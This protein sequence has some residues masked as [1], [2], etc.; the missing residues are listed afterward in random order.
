[1]NKFTLAIIGAIALIALSPNASAK[2][3]WK[4]KKPEH[5]EAKYIR[6]AETAITGINFHI[7]VRNGD[8]YI[9]AYFGSHFK[10][11]RMTVDSSTPL[12]LH[13]MD[14]DILLF[15]TTESESKKTVVLFFLNNKKTE[16][17][18]SIS[19]EVLNKLGQEELIGIQTSFKTDGEIKQQDYVVKTKSAKKVSKAAQCVLDLK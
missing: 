7:G 16:V 12:T 13:F 18:F 3:K 5:H 15:P 2:C 6:V 1:M 10:G 4:I 11:G 9:F 19:A 14:E 8:Y 17:L